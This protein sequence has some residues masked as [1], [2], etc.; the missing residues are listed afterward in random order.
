LAADRI[1]F[2]ETGIPVKDEE[3]I[4]IEPI[5]IKKSKKQKEDEG[6]IGITEIAPIS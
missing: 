5:K 4:K 3:I 1:D 6:V 2:V